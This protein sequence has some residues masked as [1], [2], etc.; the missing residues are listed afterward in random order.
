MV[1]FLVS[2]ATFYFFW[3]PII[4]AVNYLTLIFQRFRLFLIF[5]N[6]KFLPRL[7]ELFGDDFSNFLDAK[8]VL[9][10]TYNSKVFH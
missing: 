3:V 6:Y 9:C 4:F 1:T 10:K 5:L 2:L 8:I 7:D